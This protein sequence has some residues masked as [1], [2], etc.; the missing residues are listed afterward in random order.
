MVAKTKRH[1]YVDMHI[2][3]HPHVRIPWENEKKKK[4]CSSYINREERKEKKARRD[5]S[6]AVLPSFT[7][8]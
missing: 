7:L 3:T 5:I 1:A 4:K 8:I 2:L 6:A